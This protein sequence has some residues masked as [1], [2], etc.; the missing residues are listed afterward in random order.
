M[1]KRCRSD[2][3][4]ISLRY[5]FD[6][7]CP[8]CRFH[9]ASISS[10]YHLQYR[11]DVAEIVRF[12]QIFAQC[13]RDVE[14]V[15]IRSLN[16]VIILWRYRRD[17]TNIKFISWG[18]RGDI[19]QVDIVGVSCVYRGGIVGVSCGYVAGISRG[20]RRVPAK[21]DPVFIYLLGTIVRTSSS[22]MVISI[23]Y[24]HWMPRYFQNSAFLH[25]D[26]ALFD[27][28]PNI[29]AFSSGNEPQANSV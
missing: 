26:T 7:I 16:T 29:S 10:R 3:M 17:Y 9:I 15:F 20:Y 1:S 18:Y 2:M 12:I 5:R 22:M 19:A 13:R 24:D 21:T 8:C 6:I 27:V 25:C 28:L 11:S 4:Y 14:S 23:F